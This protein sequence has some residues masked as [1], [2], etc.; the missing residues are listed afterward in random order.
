[1]SETV[2]L[3]GLS[4]S[5]R[6]GSFATKALRNAADL[7]PVDVNLNLAE[8]GDTPPKNIMADIP[9]YNE[10]D[11]GDEFPAA[12]VELGKRV[13]EADALYISMAEYNHSM[14]G[15]FKN[16]IDWLSRLPD[17]PL[18]G[19]PF[20]IMSSSPGPLGGIRSQLSFRQSAV[21]LDMR[22]MFKPEVV[23]GFAPKK[24][25]DDG[26]LTDDMARDLIG[27]QL[28]AL[29]DWVLQLRN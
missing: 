22:P 11:R 5:L 16:A 25:D 3:L 7:A 26:K 13:A 19:K 1:M 27:K 20:G 9:L 14:P 28:I 2:N 23:I 8:L 6:K 17:L 12:V 18:G 15:G 29:R 4:A 24:Y 21:F 10:D